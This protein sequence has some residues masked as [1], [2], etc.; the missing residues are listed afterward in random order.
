MR[1][2]YIMK[3]TRLYLTMFFLTGLIL[4]A[5]GAYLLAEIDRDEKGSPRQSRPG[6]TS[7][8][9][10]EQEHSSSYNILFLGGDK[11]NNNTDTVI[12]VNVDPD[13]PKISLLSIPRDTRV[14][15]EGRVRKINF[16]YPRGGG[17]LAVKTVEELLGASVDFY[18]FIDLA[19]FRKT[20]D[21]LGGVEFYVPEDMHYDDPAQNLHIH[22]K[23][24]YQLLDGRKAEYLVRYRKGYKNG[25]IGRIKMQQEFIKELYRQKMTVTNLPRLR[26]VLIMVFDNLKTNITLD[27]ALNLL[28]MA[29]KVKSSDIHF[30][31]LPG[32]VSDN[33]SW[34]FIMDSEQASEIVRQNFNA[35]R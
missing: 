21:L 4:F 13:T 2:V 7:S 26:N 14:I 3:T 10:W 34:L 17:D 11:V 30:Y 29:D 27:R 33:K 19:V 25:D 5:A 24:G 22:L 20:I 31:R 1:I 18:V 9:K 6:K 8:V 23:K 12:L 28:L 16:A 35:V 15:I 32:R